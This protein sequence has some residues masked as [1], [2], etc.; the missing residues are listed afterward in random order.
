MSKNTIKML[1][2]RLDSA[3][4]STINVPSP[5]ISVCSLDGSGAYCEGCLRSLDEIRVWSA[6][7]DAQKKEV[8]ERIAQRIARLTATP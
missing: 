3:R 5:C 2:T 8:W 1:A 4:A 6:N 7:T